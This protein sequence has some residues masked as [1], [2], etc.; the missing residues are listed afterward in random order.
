M[1]F[2]DLEFKSHSAGIGGVQA[3]KKFSNGWGISVIRA[4]FS[5]GGEKGLY[6][7]AVFGQDGKLHY[8]NL[9]AKRDV[10]GYLTSKEVEKLGTQVEKF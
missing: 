8:D 2:S 6:E 5:Y 9:V 3:K 7:L 4:S 10:R 1:K